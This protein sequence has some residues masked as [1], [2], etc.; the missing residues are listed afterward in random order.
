MPM[1]VTTSPWGKYDNQ[2]PD[3]LIR[4][5]WIGALGIFVLGLV[6]AIP[7]DR[8]G[9]TCWNMGRR[10]KG[11]QMVTVKEFNPWSG[12]NGIGFVTN[13]RKQMLSIPLAFSC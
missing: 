10:L 2:S 4:P 1:W 3:D 12:G 9:C 13:T 8:R 11:P 7:L 6:L 5:A